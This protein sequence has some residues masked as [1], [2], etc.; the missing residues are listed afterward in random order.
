MNPKFKLLSLKDNTDAIFGCL[1]NILFVE[2][3]G[4]HLK[5]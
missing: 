4:L 1:Q 5:F 2:F 3:V